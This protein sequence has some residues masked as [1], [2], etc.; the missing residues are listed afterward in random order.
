MLRWLL[1]GAALGLIPVTLALASSRPQRSTYLASPL[2]DEWRRTDRT[3]SICSLATSKAQ[4]EGWNRALRG[5][6]SLMSWL[7]GKSIEP[8]TGIGRHPFDEAEC[9]FFF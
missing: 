7:D 2:E 5:D 9:C 1:C 4:R 3:G 6:P 8:L